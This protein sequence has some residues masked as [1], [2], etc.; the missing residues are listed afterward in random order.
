MNATYL[1]QMFM[2]PEDLEMNGFDPAE[3]PERQM[4]RSRGTKLELLKLR[5]V[6][7]QRQPGAVEMTSV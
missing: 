6:R 1:R 4:D 3:R 2:P 7:V 5:R